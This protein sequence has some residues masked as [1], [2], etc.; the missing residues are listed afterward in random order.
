MNWKDISKYSYTVES[1]KFTLARPSHPFTIHYQGP[2]VVYSEGDELSS[3]VDYRFNLDFTGNPLDNKHF[4]CG[5]WHK[6]YIPP[7][8][9]IYTSCLYPVE[10][11]DSISSESLSVLSGYFNER[12]DH[13]GYVN[14]YVEDCGIAVSAG[15]FRAVV[16]RTYP[17]ES[18]NS[19]SINLTSGIFKDV[20][21]N[22]SPI[23]S[24]NS[25]SIG[26]TSGIFRDVV[27]EYNYWPYEGI[28]DLGISIVSGIHGN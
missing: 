14:D 5:Y 27:I 10:F 3:V 7:F 26:I 12:V 20:V 18:V 2:K 21:H 6:N 8:T 23:E 22:Y 11:G 25:T 24:V 9:I 16:L 17:V 19:T 28:E 1:A 4:P 15:V 13:Y